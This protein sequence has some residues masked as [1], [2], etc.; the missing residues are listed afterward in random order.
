MPGAVVTNLDTVFRRH[1]KTVGPASQGGLMA[2][3]RPRIDQAR[4][5]N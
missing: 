1:N 4:V 5:I 3:S 2:G